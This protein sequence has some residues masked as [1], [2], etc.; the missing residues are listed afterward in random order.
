VKPVVHFESFRVVSAGI[1]YDVE[2]LVAPPQLPPHVSADS[3][4]YLDP[5]T[6]LTVEIIHILQDRI[7]VVDTL[8]DEDR[9][10]IEGLIELEAAAKHA[11]GVKTASVVR[12]EPREKQMELGL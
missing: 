11:N 9:A 8:A 1:A 12:Y 2:C 4:R 5:G 3:P 7:D 6:P 10:S